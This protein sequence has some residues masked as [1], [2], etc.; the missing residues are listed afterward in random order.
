MIMTR[1]GPD[2]ATL[3]YSMYVYKTAFEFGR[4]GYASALAWVQI[5]VTILL[6]AVVVVASRRFIH[7]RGA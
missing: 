4:M 1:G 2:N 7:Y 3:T 5:L 6:A